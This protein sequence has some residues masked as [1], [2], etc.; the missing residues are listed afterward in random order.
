MCVCVGKWLYC[1]GEDG[2]MYMFDMLSGQLE[3][4]LQLTKEAGS[5]EEIIGIAHH[6]HRNIITS[7]ADNG[8]LR[9]WKP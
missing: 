2:I 5:R 4:V 7:I 1:V 8:Q 9:L 3:S 6:P